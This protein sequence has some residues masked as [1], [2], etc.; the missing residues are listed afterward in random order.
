MYL[1]NSTILNKISKFLERDIAFTGL[2]SFREDFDS[3]LFR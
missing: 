3:F 2:V 1:E